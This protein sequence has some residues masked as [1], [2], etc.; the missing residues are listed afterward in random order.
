MRRGIVISS[1]LI[2]FF[3]TGLIYAADFD[4]I[5]ST[6]TFGVT[7]EFSV[8]IKIDSGGD[9]INAAQAKIQFSSNTL[10]VKSISK[11]GSIFNFWLQEPEFSNDTGI[12]EFIGGTPSGVSGGSLQALKINFIAKGVGSS[13][14]SFLDAAITASDGSGTNILSSSNGASFLVSSSASVP[15]VEPG[16]DVPTQPV[17]VATPIQ[18]KRTPI[19]AIGL[20]GA[21]KIEIPLYPNPEDW[22]NL[23]SQFHVSWSLPLDVSDV[24][25]DL[26]S[27]PTYDVPK[28]SEGLF[29]NNSFSSFE[30]DGI[31]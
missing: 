11:D 21:P 9:S 26:N 24:A 20:P 14:F 19:E 17:P 16:Q 23:I 12:I 13:D 1:L 18:I 7:Q 25:T 3:F 2:S 15:R 30:E 27:N 5:P 28:S 4:V 10:Q 6:G 8:N 29:E 31:Y 22:Y